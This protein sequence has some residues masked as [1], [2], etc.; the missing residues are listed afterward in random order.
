MSN[1]PLSRPAC[2]TAARL[3]LVALFWCLAAVGHTTLAQTAAP[4]AKTGGSANV[5]VLGRLQF[6]G[7]FSTG[8]VDIEQE[9]SRPYVYVSGMTD[10]PGFWVVSV[11]DPDRKSV[12]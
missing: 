2:V 8:G 11:A 6:D 12:V 10:D 5:K 1:R 9:P 3:P 7:Y 4:R